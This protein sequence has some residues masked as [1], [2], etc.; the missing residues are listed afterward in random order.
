[1]H[2]HDWQNFVQIFVSSAN[3]F[4]IVLNPM[5]SG[6]SCT[7]IKNRSGSSTDPCGTPL[8]TS[9]HSATTNL[10]LHHFMSCR[11]S[12]VQV[13]MTLPI[14]VPSLSFPTDFSD[15][16]VSIKSQKPSYTIR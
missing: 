14:K 16:F 13:D 9:I 1:M 11:K 15:E 4:D 5:Q 6:K 10:H 3:N 12:P 7:K 8:I 2:R